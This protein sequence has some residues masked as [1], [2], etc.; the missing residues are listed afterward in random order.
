MKIKKDDFKKIGVPMEL[1]DQI[2]EDADGF[3]QHPVFQTLGKADKENKSLFVE[4]AKGMKEEPFVDFGGY[5]IPNSKVVDWFVIK[6]NKTHKWN[7]KKL[8]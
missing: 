7:P 5:K 2:E 6:E 8:I 4:V 3:Y 1:F